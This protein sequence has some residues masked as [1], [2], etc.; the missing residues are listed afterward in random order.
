MPHPV[1]RSFLLTA[2]LMTC[3]A[4]VAITWVVVCL[5]VAVPF[6]VIGA[7]RVEFPVVDAVGGALF[8]VFIVIGI[9]AKSAAWK[10]EAQRAV[11]VA[12]FLVIMLGILALV[13]TQFAIAWSTADEPTKKT[14]LPTLQ[15]CW[16]SA[17]YWYSRSWRLVSTLVRHRSQTC[18][19]PTATGVRRT[20]GNSRA[21]TVGWPRGRESFLLTR[22]ANVSKLPSCHDAYGLPAAAGPIS[23]RPLRPG[24][25]TSAG[26]S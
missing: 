6:T 10:P 13:V 24:V 16:A 18:H 21:G 5:Y 1:R 14:R 23:L 22:K 15:G 11:V 7:K 25:R 17:G 20:K 19:R 4:Y 8:V 9:V 2:I 12:G 3:A 26:V